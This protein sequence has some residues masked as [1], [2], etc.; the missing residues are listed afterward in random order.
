LNF[1]ILSLNDINSKITIRSSIIVY[2]NKIV[3]ANICFDSNGDFITNEIFGTISYSSVIVNPST[4]IYGIGGGS[5]NLVFGFSINYTDSNI[6][7]SHFPS[8]IKTTSY[9]NI[10]IVYYTYKEL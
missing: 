5:S 2:I 10:N 4:S 6:I 7:S 8:V 9:A 3:I 1:K